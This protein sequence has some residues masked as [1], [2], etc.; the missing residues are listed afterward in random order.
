MILISKYLGKIVTK[1]FQSHSNSQKTRI[2][3]LILFVYLL[4]ILNIFETM[5]L[6]NWSTSDTYF[7][8]LRYPT[9]ENLQ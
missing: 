4:E 9:Q 6:M 1:H 7:K 8:E 3:S 5:K 2:Y